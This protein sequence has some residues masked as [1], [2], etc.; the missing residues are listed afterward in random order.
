[1]K[2]LTARATGPS[3]GREGT[4]I[5]DSD[6]GIPGGFLEEVAQSWVLENRMGE[7][8]GGRAGIDM[9][10]PGNTEWGGNF[11]HQRPSDGLI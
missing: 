9:D 7:G 4:H 6:S 10:A 5:A 11:S 2:G 1:M 8:A 3:D